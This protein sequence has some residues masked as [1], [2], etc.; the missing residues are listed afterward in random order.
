M[1][2]VRSVLN[3]IA[4]YARRFCYLLAPL[5]A[6][7]IFLAMCGT[8]GLY[9]FGDKSIAWC[10]MN[11][12]IIPLMADFKDILER[13]QSFSI[14][15]ANA[16][17]MDFFGI[18]F[19]YMSNP[20][21]FLIAFVSK[22]DLALF[23][24]VLVMFKVMAIAG[25]AA[26]Y[27]KRKHPKLN[28]MMIL[29]LSLIY[30]F[31]GYT[32]MYYQL[33]M[34]L[35]MLYLFPL[36]LWG[37]D[38]LFEKNNYVP[39]MILIALCIACDF[40]IGGMI[41]FFTVMYVGIRLYV[42]RKE[43]RVAPIAKSFLLGSFFAAL[44]DAFIYIPSFIQYLESGRSDSLM[45]SLE[46]SWFITPY[47]T[48]I[49]LVLCLVNLFPLFFRK[50][51]KDRVNR[52][53]FVLL[54]IPL[55]LEPL[56]KIWHF[57]SYQ[58]FPARFAFMTIFMGIEI[59]ASNL[60]TLTDRENFD[61]RRIWG[62]LGS[63]LLLSVAFL[64]ENRFVEEK[65][66][67]L[68]RYASSLWG[69]GTSFECLCRYYVMILLIVT[70][71]YLLFR[72][73]KTNRAS[74]SLMMVG[75]SVIEAM[76]S[77]RIYAVVPARKTESYQEF[78]KLEGAIDDDAF[79]RV[80][81]S[82]KITDVNMVGAI[83]YNN[84]GHYTS[85]TNEDYMFTMKK[86]GYSSYWMEVGAYGGTEF[87]DALMVNKYTI[88]PGKNASAIASTDRYSITE[89]PVLPFGLVTRGD[90]S[91]E[92]ELKED[93]RFKMQE[94]IFDTLFGGDQDLTVSYGYKTSG[95]NDLSDADRF[96]FKPTSSASIT[97]TCEIR[98]TQTL[99]FDCFDRYSNSLGETI[100]GSFNI[101]VNGMMRQSNYPSQSFNGI[102]KLGSFTDTTVQV[103]IEV[104]KEVECRSFGVFG[105]QKDV[106]D[107]MI[108]DA[109]GAN[110]RVQGSKITGRFDNSEGYSYLFLS[111][112][113]SEGYRAKING[114]KADVIRVFSDFIAI[115]LKEGSNT[116]FVSYATPGIGIGTAATICGALLLIFHLLLRYKYK[117]NYRYESS[118]ENISFQ[119]V[120]FFAASL[121]IA[122]YL[123]PLIVNIGHEI[124]LFL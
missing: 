75:F 41:V 122:L 124:A 2:K 47:Q 86:L 13:K 4:F 119:I 30:A 7:I 116:I 117:I 98:G 32:M 50:G 48:V 35:D 38:R 39:Y 52:A 23:M 118:V 28:A 33:L 44:I 99:Y 92:A 72:F 36:L 123:L 80:K 111:I 81:T 12:Q 45:N 15:L 114:Q 65:I 88:S 108:S 56:N 110:L 19:F 64:I 21:T 105:I 68:S 49:P 95:L 100:N 78:L 58:A 91:D 1:E 16:G 5:V 76:F 85:L 87:G 53:M 34:W 93:Q 102:L 31:S 66:G 113:Y 94:H 106:F 79:Y 96:H 82:A 9:P 55:I 97:Y 67:Y 70:G 26:F 17:G 90:L 120:I 84:L 54:L 69:D 77:M 89:N 62:D 57:G 46:N 6:G 73:K 51:S 3:K 8:H 22:S 20:F 71:V 29:A 115:P 112:P 11:Q 109:A 74:F 83:G 61:R 103:T 121:L 14:N 24:N 107:A 37:I 10:D 18:F 101:R 104:L 43:N 60:E 40:Y 63:V 59:A 27:L 42:E 25:S